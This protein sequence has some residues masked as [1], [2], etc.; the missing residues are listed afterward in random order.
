VVSAAGCLRVNPGDRLIFAHS[1][2]MVMNGGL[3]AVD[4][5]F[6]AGKPGLSNSGGVLVL[7]VSGQLVDQITWASAKAGRSL[8]LDPDATDAGQNDL[9][10]SFCD[11]ALADVYG[12]GDKGTPGAANPQCPLVVPPGMCDDGGNV[13]AIVSP[14]A[15]QLEITEL[16]PNPALVADASG[17]WFEVHATANVDL[18]GLQIGKAFPTVDGTVSSPTCLEVPAGGYAILAR[19]LDPMVNG[20]LPAAIAPFSVSLPQT[21][22]GLFVAVGGTLLDT[23]AY[24]ASTSGTSIIVDADGTVCNAPAGTAAYNGTDIGTPAADNGAQCP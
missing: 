13:R 17:E 10:A 20:M 3:P 11:A 12:A 22:P 5:V 18:N 14:M 4:V 23:V 1:N 24:A 16:M 8:A 2:D 6:P 15:G 7:S 9:A 19:N 21:G